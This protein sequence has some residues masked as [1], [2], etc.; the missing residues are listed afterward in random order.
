VSW[1]YPF[2][3]ALGPLI[4][5]LFAG[6]AIIIKASENVAWSSHFFI[7]AVRRILDALGFPQ[8]VVQLVT[9]WPEHADALTTHEDIGH[10]TFIGSEPIG[11]LVA[12]A[13][14]KHLTPTVI[15]LGGKDPAVILPSADLKYFNSTFLRSVFQGGGQNCIGLERF[16][17]ARSLLP[18]FISLVQARI[19][20]LRCGS[21]L[22]D[23]LP[24]PHL[25]QPSAVDMGAMINSARFD[26]LEGLISNA[27]Q[28][29]AEVLVGGQRLQSSTW[30][31]GCFFAPTLITGVTR[32][33]RI[34]QE[35]VFAPIMLIMPFDT[36][37]EAI[38]IANSTRYGLGSSVF[39]AKRDECQYVAKRLRSGMV[40]INDFGVSY[41]AQSLPFGGVKASGYGRF[42]G[43]EGLLGL[44]IAKAVTEDRFFRTVR[45]GIP[46]P[47]DYPLN[48]QAWPFVRSLVEFAYGSSLVQRARGIVGL[49]RGSL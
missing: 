31:A 11:K 33:M 48:A 41:L 21:Y 49:I 23:A 34:A 40:N 29:G 2:H 12:A 46:P 30:K 5:A 7:D 45:T 3:N 42:G 15:E 32:D 27:V 25:A 26:E 36:L 38:E 44:T 6:N 35:E 16:I 9:C 28:K 39:G 13:A 24:G 1:N 14:V 4:A 8:D 47:L 10:I 43:P 20:G 17:V 22:D 37:D 18:Q 19:E